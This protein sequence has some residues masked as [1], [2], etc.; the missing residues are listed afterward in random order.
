MKIEKGIPL[1]SKSKYPWDEMEAGDSFFVKEKRER[2]KL[3]S[4]CH[5]RNKKFPPQKYIV[6]NFEDGLRVWRIK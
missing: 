6:R 1:P 4:A 5:M 3:A 2:G